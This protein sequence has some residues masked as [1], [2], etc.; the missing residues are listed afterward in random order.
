MDIVIKGGCTAT[1]GQVEAR[2]AC[3][4][5][6]RRPEMQRAV[7]ALVE[8][9]ATSRDAKRLAHFGLAEPHRCSFLSGAHEGRHRCACGHMWWEVACRDG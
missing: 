5:A 8:A 2:K 4:V 9:D 6:L 3:S 1:V 7:E